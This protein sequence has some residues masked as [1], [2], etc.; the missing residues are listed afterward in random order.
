[1]RRRGIEFYY[2][3]ITSN[4]NKTSIL[5]IRFDIFD[6]ISSYLDPCNPTRSAISYL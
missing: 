1:M 5:Y 3:Q 2:Y 4:I 6:K